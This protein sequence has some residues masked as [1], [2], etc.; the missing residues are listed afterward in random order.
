MPTESTKKVRDR[1]LDSAEELFGQKGYEPV[2]MRTVAEQAGVHISQIVYH[3]TNKNLLVRAI[4]MRRADDLNRERLQMLDYYRRAIGSAKPEVSALLRA[5]L[6]PFFER[7]S[8]G[9]PGWRNYSAF[10]GRI[11][12]DPNAASHINDAFNEVAQKYIGASGEALPEVSEEKIHWGFQFLLACMY[13][14]EETNTRI[15][16]LSKNKFSGK[17]L[18]SAFSTL[19]PFLSAGFLSMLTLENSQPHG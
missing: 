19:I 3:F 16:H 11:I 12:W 17:D 9:D 4:V 6:S 18:D 5:F 1:I 13:S 8:S 2:S 7:R 14:V 15:E 10:I